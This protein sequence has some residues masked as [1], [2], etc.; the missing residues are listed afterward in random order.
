MSPHNE[1]FVAVTPAELVALRGIIADLDLILDASAQFVPVIQPRPGSP[2]AVAYSSGNPD[3]RIGFDTGGLLLYAAKDHLAA[4]SMITRA[5][6][7][8][9]FALYTLLRGAAE[10]VVRARHLL[11]PQI[12]AVERHTRSFN[13]RLENAVQ[14]GKINEAAAEYAAQRMPY[15]VSRAEGLSISAKR[16]SKSEVIAFGDSRPSIFDNFDRY[17]PKGGLL[18]RYLSA[19]AH[20][21]PW[22]LIERGRAQPTADPGV[23]AA[24]TDVNVRMA[25]TLLAGVASLYEQTV[26]FWLGLA[27]QPPGTWD[28]AK[29][30]S[31]GPHR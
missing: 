2:L 15:L 13:E 1:P 28:A 22:A 3:E 12:S 4:I 30:G 9:S 20:S 29:A 19:F 5:G 16:N 21:Q 14:A 24:P 6:V 11:D 31:V 10:P 27:G 18:F 23:S 8:P 25:L 17:L 26:G 7:L